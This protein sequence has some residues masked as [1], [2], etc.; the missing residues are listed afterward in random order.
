MQLLELQIYVLRV[1]YGVCAREINLEHLKRMAKRKKK[2][3]NRERIAKRKKVNF[4]QLSDVSNLFSEKEI[5]AGFLMN[6]I[7]IR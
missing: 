5:K 7:T 6:H 1:R 4:C 2:R 3:K